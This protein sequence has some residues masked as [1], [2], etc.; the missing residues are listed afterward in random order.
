MKSFWLRECCFLLVYLL[1]SLCRLAW[2]CWPESKRLWLVGFGS[3]LVLLIL[4]WKA[5]VSIL[6]F[7]GHCGLTVG[8][9]VWR[10]LVAGN[11]RTQPAEVLT[12]RWD[13]LQRSSVGEAKS[14]KGNFLCSSPPWF[15][16]G[17]IVLV[18]AQTQV[19]MVVTRHCLFF[20]KRSLKI[21][22][23]LYV[24]PECQHCQYLLFYWAILNVYFFIS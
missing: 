18:I 7:L 1:R 23:D 17:E 2:W 24:V 22:Q 19:T 20:S 10:K 3:Q 5:V 11:C 16:L 14:L 15:F 21:D 13:L 6:L 12:W 4:F 9:D 8:G